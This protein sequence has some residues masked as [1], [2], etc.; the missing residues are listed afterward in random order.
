[1]STLKNGKTEFSKF[2]KRFITACGTAN[3]RVISD[4]LDISY[5]AAKNY[6]NGRLPEP[7][8]LIKIAEK[9]PY[10][11]HWLLTGEGDRF[12]DHSK[13]SEAELLASVLSEIADASILRKMFEVISDERIAAALSGSRISESHETRTVSISRNSIREEKEIALEP[14]R[15]QKSNR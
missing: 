6:L 8:V 2:Q 7:K 5:Q 1:M 15:I 10:S 12:V 13:K 9:T 14:T 3:A 4:Y 11:V